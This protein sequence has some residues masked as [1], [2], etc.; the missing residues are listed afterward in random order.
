MQKKLFFLLF[1]WIIALIL[2]FFCK[3]KK[4][5]W[6]ENI[7]YVLCLD[8]NAPICWEYWRKTKLTK[9]YSILAENSKPSS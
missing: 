8:S 1:Y 3:K 6:I 9:K 2:F 4:Y 7:G 5:P